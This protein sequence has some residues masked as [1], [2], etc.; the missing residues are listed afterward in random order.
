MK[1]IFF[2]SLI[3]HF[4]F[5]LAAQNVGIGTTTPSAKLEVHH[6]SSS[7][8]G[9]KLIDSSSNISGSLQFQNINYTTG[10]RLQGFAASNF[11]NGQYLDI[12][13]DTAITATF[14]GNG[15][16]GVRNLEPTYPLDVTGDINTTGALRVNGN[17]GSNGQ[18]LRSNGSGGMAWADICNYQNMAT[19]TS[20][21]GSWAV[22]VGVTKVWV[23]AWGAGGGGSWYSG[24]GGG[25]YISAFFTVSNGNSI[26][27][28]IG[29]AGAS[30][31]ATSGNGGNTTIGYSPTPVSLSANGGTGSSLTGSFVLGGNG[32]LA[33]ATGTNS[34]FSSYGQSGQ[35]T[36]S[37]A[38]QVSATSFYEEITGGNGGN[39]GNTTATGGNESFMIINMSSAST[40]RASSGDSGNPPGGGGGSGYIAL[41]NPTA[42]SSSGGPGA[43]GRVVIH[44]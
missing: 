12:R 23:E 43:Q 34:Y 25:G 31:G 10:I 17:P 13:S 44:Y 32:G 9:L 20:G 28:T 27:Y 26:S 11:N 22:P 21:S 42:A 16:M 38:F 35:V 19:F 7:A 30:G 1:T 6:R 15:F 5:K 18:F 4:S 39:A 36:R 3:L 2:F 8:F 24:G 37:R 29:A 33:S 14:K 40:A 41:L